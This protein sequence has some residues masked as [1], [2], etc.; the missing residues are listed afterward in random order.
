[1][2]KILLI[3]LAT[4]VL[5]INCHAEKTTIF[6]HVIELINKN[7]YVD[8]YHELTI[9]EDAFKSDIEKYE[10]DYLFCRILKTAFWESN[11]P[12][13]KDLYVEKLESL[14]INSQFSP[15]AFKFID[16]SMFGKMIEDL[17]LYYK[18]TSNSNFDKLIRQIRELDYPINE[19]IYST[20]CHYYDYLIGKRDFYSAYHDLN[21]FSVK[22]RE[23]ETDETRVAHIFHLGAIAVLFE[24]LGDLKDN[25]YKAHFALSMLDN[26]KR[27]YKN[28]QSDHLDADFAVYYHG[29]G[30]H[31]KAQK[32]LNDNKMDVISRYGTNGI[33]YAWYLFHESLIHYIDNNKEKSKELAIKAYSLSKNTT[34]GKNELYK[35]KYIEALYAICSKPFEKRIETGVKSLAYYSDRIRSIC[36][37]LDD[38]DDKLRELIAIQ[39]D[40]EK[41]SP[42]PTTAY[43]ECVSSIFFFSINDNEKK[44]EVIAL[45]GDFGV[46]YEEY[47]DKFGDSFIHSILSGGHLKSA[48]LSIMGA[49]GTLKNNNVLRT[50]ELVALTSLFAEIDLKSENW[51]KA[52]QS[53]SHLLPFVIKSES[54]HLL[55]AKCLTELSRCHLKLNDRD[56]CL[57]YLDL[58]EKL[59]P[60]VDYMP[61][62]KNM[63]EIYNSLAD[64]HHGLRNKLKSLYYSN[65]VI[66]LSDNMFSILPLRYSAMYRKAELLFEEKKY[67]ECSKLLMPVCLID[68][69]LRNYDFYNSMLIKSLCR[70]NDIGAYDFLK[71]YVDYTINEIVPVY[72]T[73]LSQF[74]RDELWSLKSAKIIQLCTEVAQTFKNNSILE[75]AYNHIMF[76]KSLD[77]E[78]QKL[79]SK[80]I[81][82][83]D[84]YLQDVYN[85][86][87][88]AQDSLNYG[89]PKNKL[90][91]KNTIAFAQTH[92]ANIIHDE[93]LLDT[94]RDLFS[95]LKKVK[96]NTAIV[97]FVSIPKDNDIQYCAYITERNAEAPKLIYVCNSSDIAPFITTKASDINKIYSDKHRLYDL[98]W[99]NIDKHL[100]DSVDH[101]ILVPTGILNRVNFNAIP[102]DRGILSDLYSMTRVM[103]TSSLF[104]RKNRMNKLDYDVA[105]FG[106]ITYD[107]SEKEIIEES[108]R[109]INHN[110][111]YK[112]SIEQRNS[113][114][115]IKPLV[116][117]LWEIESIN[118]QL[119]K[120]DYRTKKFTKVSAS[121]AAFKQ[122]S[123]NSPLII[124]I[125]THGFYLDNE[126]K[127]EQLK[128]YNKHDVIQFKEKSLIYSGLLLSGA[129]YLWNGNQ[130]EPGVEDGILTA[131]EISRMD[132]SGTSL[133]VLSACETA[134]GD[135]DDTEGVLGLQRAFK[136]AGVDNVVMSLWPVGDKQT[137][138]LMNCFYENLQRNSSINDALQDAMREVRSIYPNPTD[139]AGFVVLR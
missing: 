22:L 96:K 59:I 91:H 1:M 121:E 33:E 100:N 47:K 15:N 86:L 106:G 37:D 54:N 21:S 11:E 137:A 105:L 38:T 110:R 88:L 103:N 125:A 116:H 55:L 17:S 77:L 101:I 56:S 118:K 97:E 39:M 134:L 3:I 75:Y 30:E 72:F 58:A 64:I 128:Y 45:P 20:Y 95:K 74:E 123:G 132:L 66:Q 102:C 89:D 138:M 51:I 48:Q 12:Y 18:N 70:S 85:K 57:V 109:Y 133:V 139:W 99:T 65:K 114:G 76:V 46:M 136:K 27:F 122:F 126:V 104:T 67:S 35:L 119:C 42:F 107:L 79:I 62:T 98:L 63:A 78:A 115:K 10:C 5:H 135:I 52:K 81:S 112:R 131:D 25:D 4:F 129:Q 83:K 19:N 40:L 13:F 113:R 31:S 60:H 28:G 14:S 2:K 29:M 41:I 117:T 43:M 16:M 23:M 7:Q 53:Y 94:N 127:K 90:I 73:E 68:K 87:L 34:I 44:K 36:S 108:N 120:K 69:R 82:N 32:L 50:G 92:L 111:N 130:L 49:I 84:K 26:A 80:G 6:N 71:R 8:A 124:H 61:Y 9:N 24:S 93:H